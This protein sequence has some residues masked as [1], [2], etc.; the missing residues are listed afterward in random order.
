VDAARIRELEPADL[1]ALAALAARTWS[2]A[3]GASVS[4]EDDAK[5]LANRR[6]EAFFAATSDERTTLVAEVGGE[7]VSY[8]QLSEGRLHRLY[9]ETALQ[10]QG[11]GRQLLDAALGHPRVAAATEV[12]LQVW[13][14]N[15][16]AV[17][18]YESV[19]FER[20][21]TTRFTVGAAELEDLLMIRRRS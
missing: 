13:E 1:P 19:G 8:V 2:D 16:R 5:E 12:V 18:L 11:L 20:V 14:K 15:E 9:V 7:L 10:G 4:P 21:G 6:S 3:F 17:R